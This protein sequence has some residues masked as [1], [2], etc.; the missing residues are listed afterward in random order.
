MQSVISEW[1]KLYFQILN[2]KIICI[3]KQ[4]ILE[5]IRPAPNSILKCII[6]LETSFLLDW[7]WIWVTFLKD[8]VENSFHDSLNLY[9]NRRSGQIQSSS[10]Y[11]QPCSQYFK[12]AQ[13]SWTIWV[14]STVEF[15]KI[16]VLLLLEYFFLQ[17]PH[18][19][20]LQIPVAILDSTIE[21]IIANMRFGLPLFISTY[22][23]Q[24][25]F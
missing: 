17:M 5:Y 8:K 24:V 22:H 6:L 15:W 14:I 25:Y 7:D 21:N 23:Y 1:N 12:K 11:L 9:Y 4:N 13:T 16:W 10:H 20:I 2:L 19:M 3:F 18:L